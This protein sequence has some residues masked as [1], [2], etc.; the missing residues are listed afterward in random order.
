MGL[1]PVTDDVRRTGGGGLERAADDVEVGHCRDVRRA[2][3]AAGLVDVLTRP[4]TPPPPPPSSSSST[5]SSLKSSCDDYM[6]KTVQNS[7][8]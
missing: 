8:C 3:A 1:V 4:A 2:I 5:S 7:N 6:E